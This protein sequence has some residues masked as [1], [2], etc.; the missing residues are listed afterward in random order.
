M[1]DITADKLT[2]AD[3]A[4]AGMTRR[5]VDLV[6]KPPHYAFSIEPIDAIESWGFDED[7]YLAS[8]VAYVV[9]SK[10]KGT[11]L[12]DLEKAAWYLARKIQRVKEGK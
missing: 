3:I 8:V 7:H 4:A 9:R 11:E 5:T 6:N 1:N 12:L 10:H 2:D